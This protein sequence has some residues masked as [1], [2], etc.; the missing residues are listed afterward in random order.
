[1]N[2]YSASY[3][4]YGYMYMWVEV[5]SFEENELGDHYLFHSCRFGEAMWRVGS[6]DLNRPDQHVALMLRALV[7]NGNRNSRINNV[8]KLSCIWII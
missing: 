5:L 1:M 6:F 7:V 3:S 2:Q 4:Y 8:R